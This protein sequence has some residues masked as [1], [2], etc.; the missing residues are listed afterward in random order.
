MFVMGLMKNMIFKIYMYTLYMYLS[1][2]VY[3]CAYIYIIK[4]YLRKD[5]IKVCVCVLSF[6]FPLLKV[7]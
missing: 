6:L 3:M 2:S 5:T 7:L 1:I 4:I